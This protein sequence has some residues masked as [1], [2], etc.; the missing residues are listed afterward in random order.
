MMGMVTLVINT[1]LFIS[2]CCWLYLQTKRYIEQS[3]FNKKVIK[4]FSSISA[5]HS[6]D[7][8]RDEMTRKLFDNQGKLAI[9]INEEM[10]L[11]SERIDNLQEK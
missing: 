7:I 8:K 1:L 10:S 9:A 6:E 11:L 4:I 2:V 5:I 3:K